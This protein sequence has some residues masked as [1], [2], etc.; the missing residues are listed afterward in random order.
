LGQARCCDPPRSLN[1]INIIFAIFHFFNLTSS[2][3]R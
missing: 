2:N 1:S 3:L